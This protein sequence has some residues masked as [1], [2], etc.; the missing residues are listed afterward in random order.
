MF[1]I[2]VVALSR[3]FASRASVAKFH[4]L[5]NNLSVVSDKVTDHAYQEMYGNYLLPYI[6][7]SRN[8]GK[9]I[10]FLEIGLGCTG[11]ELFG[12]SIE[13]WNKL[14]SA[15]D[16]LWSADYEGGCI[17]KARAAGKLHNFKTLVGDQ[18]NITVLNQWMKQSGGHFDIIIDDGGHVNAQIYNTV[19]TLWEHLKPGGLFFIEDLQVG[20]REPHYIRGIPMVEVIKDWLEQLL[21]EE[22][23]RKYTHKIMPHVKA[24]FCQWEACVLVKCNETDLGRCKRDRIAMKNTIAG[25]EP[26]KK[27]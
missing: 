2:A 11:D 8:Q 21:I 7:E 16:D 17:D 24:L 13:I 15:K 1:I 19:Y 12:G 27:P 3:C 26:D 20:R 23:N 4:D 22:K 6:K 25:I 10:K 18:E 5:V 9:S 14:F